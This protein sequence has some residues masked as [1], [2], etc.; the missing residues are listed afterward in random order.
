MSNINVRLE[1]I[2]KVI[3]E[4]KDSSNE[5]EKEDKI[6]EFEGNLK[7]DTTMLNEYPNIKFEFVDMLNKIINRVYTGNNNHKDK[8]QLD[9]IVDKIFPDKDM[10][11]GKKAKKAKK[12]KKTK[13]TK[14]DRRQR[15]RRQRQ[16]RQR[17][18]RQRQRRQRQRKEQK[19][20]V[21]WINK[22]KKR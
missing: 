10:S 12:A 15:Q 7:Q 9:V 11:G 4:I 16:R 19:E 17:Q 1:D 8:K 22:N 20:V 3:K 18:R 6:K 13:K 21:M 2:S 5:K 14:T